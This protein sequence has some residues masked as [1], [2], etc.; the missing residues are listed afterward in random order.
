MNAVTRR[1]LLE[2]EQNH[3]GRQ[4]RRTQDSLKQQSLYQLADKRSSPGTTQ[5]GR[6]KA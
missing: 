3:A 1:N 6:P 5:S 2:N 4:K